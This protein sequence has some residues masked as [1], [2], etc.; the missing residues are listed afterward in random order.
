M[1]PMMEMFV[2]ETNQ[3]LEQLEQIMIQSE[4]NGVFSVDDINNVFRIMHT[5][6]GSAAMM[7]VNE[8]AALA[9]A[10]EDIFFYLRENKPQIVN[11]SAL[12]D[13]IL[14]AS[15]FIKKEIDKLDAGEKANGLAAELMD[16]TKAA[17][18]D[19]KAANE[20]G[21]AGG[22]NAAPPPCA[23]ETQPETAL[24]VNAIIEKIELEDAANVFRALVFYQDDC[25]MENI[26]AYTLITHLKSHVAE[27]YFFPDQILEDD[28][29]SEIIRQQGFDLCFTTSKSYDEIFAL[30]NQ[31]IF[32]KELKLTQLEAVSQWDHSPKD[33]EAA[34]KP[35]TK[36][37]PA[38]EVP[39]KAV[40]KSEGKENAN[41]Q[42]MISVNVHK[43]DLLMDLVGELVIAEAM[44][45][46]NPD[47][48]GLE[49]KSFNKSARQL[50]KI[51]GELQDGV[52]A[53]RMVPLTGTFQK[54]NRIVRDMS[55][56]LNKSVALHL[57]GEETEV[58][59]NVIEHISDPLMHLIRNS[60]D[61][62]IEL[63][64]ER[65]K[66]G[67]SSTGNIPLEAKNAGSEVVINILDDG[68][69]LDRNRILKKARENQ[70]IHKNEAEL[71]DKEIYSFILAPGFSTNEQVTEF[72]GR[73]VGM[74]VVTKN[75]HAV[76]GNI[77]V[78]SEP[79]KG[80]ITTLKIPLTLAIISGMTIKIGRSHYTVPMVSIRESFRP[81]AKDIILDPDDN[82]MIMVRGQCHPIV[83][84]H[85]L[86]GIKTD[87]VELTEGIMVMVKTEK[88]IIGLFADALLGQQQIV[89]KPI[90]SFIKSISKT[91][92]ITGCTLLGDGNISLILDAAG[93]AG[94]I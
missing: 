11:C 38:A 33:K 67:K 20:G 56:K 2:F 6:K 25:E 72:S 22:D 46:Q 26:R 81:L 82:E 80:C 75:I 12:V 86:Y 23:A 31:T 78:N 16:L 30:L 17:L 52:M 37:A 47:L 69:G 68:R 40:K 21:T 50:K 54:M 18:A 39:V 77:I 85:R 42:S 63:P 29:S 79:G 5:I 88:Q 28:K 13:L 24:P 32:L 9:H 65:E 83:R 73:G 48:V 92:G 15:D 53:I 70:L 93:I 45:T 76:G 71:T 64:E 49:L 34:A 4:K 10:I 89:V 84:L 62:G 87:V 59:K 58:D 74:D 51:S 60:I 8:V 66:T 90:P 3:N 57:V 1:D 14:E 35:E 19:L 94:R 27:L 44:V 7:V 55:Q 61:H 41:H 91:Q 36:E 43:L